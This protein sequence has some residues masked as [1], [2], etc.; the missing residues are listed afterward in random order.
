MVQAVIFDI[1][2]TIIDSVDLHIQAWKQT[3]ANYGK[4]VSDEL[5]RPQIG[6]G[7]DDMLP[8]FFSNEELDRFGRDLKQYRS[9]LFE[10]EY[11]PKVKA[12]PGVRELFERIKQE[13]KKIS[14]ASTAK[15]EEINIYKEIARIENL[16]DCAVCSE[17]VQQSKPHRDIC[18]VALHKLGDMASDQAI[19]VGDT[20]YDAEAASKINMRA[21]GLLCGGGNLEELHRAGCIA[22]YKHPADLLDHYEASPLRSRTEII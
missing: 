21:I 5:I 7:S 11:L 20:E 12:F 3:F 2:G 19:V 18:A 15:E 13:N 17:E 22:I 16:V 10:R 14:L 6:K 9:K 8:V 4:D 1:D